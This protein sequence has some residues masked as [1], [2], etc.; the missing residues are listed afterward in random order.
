MAEAKAQDKVN[1]AD[2][3]ALKLFIAFVGGTVVFS[4]VVF[5]FIL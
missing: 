2:A 5:I 1:E 3:V 4:A